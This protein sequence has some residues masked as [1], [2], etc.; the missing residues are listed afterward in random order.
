MI[1]RRWR[2]VGDWISRS[3]VVNTF[4]FGASAAHGLWLLCS[5]EKVEVGKG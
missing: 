1:W 2:G 4:G 3:V 5:K